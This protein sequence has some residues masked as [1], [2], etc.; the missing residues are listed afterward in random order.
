MADAAVARCPSIFSS[1]EAQRTASLLQLNPA[2]HFAPDRQAS[3][4]DDSEPGR[5][6]VLRAESPPRLRRDINRRATG[7]TI[8]FV[9]PQMP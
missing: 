7:Q 8:S 6:V 3:A 2:H 9:A 1:L 5:R 4:G